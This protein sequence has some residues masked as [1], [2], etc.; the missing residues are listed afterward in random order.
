M[1]QFLFLLIFSVPVFAYV[2][3][4]SGSALVTAILGIIAA[5]SYTFRK[6]FYALRSKIFK[7]NSNK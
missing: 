4:G 1:K 6:W 3:P 7:K 2:D 5:I